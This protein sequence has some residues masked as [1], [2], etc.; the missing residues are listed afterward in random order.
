M[1]NEK[2]AV[3]WTNKTKGE[4][5]LAILLAIFAIFVCWYIYTNTVDARSI[6]MVL[7]QGGYEQE[8]KVIQD[9]NSI[10]N[11]MTELGFRMENQETVI[12]K[13]TFPTT[14]GEDI[15]LHSTLKNKEW[16]LDA[17]YFN[18]GEFFKDARELQP[19]SRDR[20]EMDK[21]NNTIR[22]MLNDTK[23]MEREQ[24]VL[25]VTKDKLIG[26]KWRLEKNEYLPIASGRYEK[27]NRVD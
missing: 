14:Q 21:Y 7:H 13:L 27:D 4:K 24:A 25:S 22:T 26:G 8:R 11:E 9:T 15:K 1:S 10:W 12:S 23:Y 19:N 20:E 16:V 17:E 3:G 18:L 5:L 6:N 2:V